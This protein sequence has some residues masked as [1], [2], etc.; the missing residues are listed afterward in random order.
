MRVGVIVAME[1]ELDSLKTQV[2]N[3]K[4]I[5]TDAYEFY[6]ASINHTSIIVVRSGIGKVNAA[7]CAT[8]LIHNFN[9]DMVISTGVAGGLSLKIKPNDVVIAKE[10]TYHDVYCGG[11][12]E[13]GS[14]QGLPKMY[15]SSDYLV[16]A[17]KKVFEESHAGLIVSG[18]KFVHGKVEKEYILK[19]FPNAL[20]VDME[21]CAIA[22]TCYLCNV[23]FM[24]LRVI[25]D[26]CDE[27]E[28][29]RF[30]DEIANVLS[31][32]VLSIIKRIDF[33]YAE[34]DTEYKI[35]SFEIDHLDLKR[36]VYVCRKDR[37]GDEVLTT[38]DVR[39]KE[40]YKDNPLEQDAVHTIEHIGATYLRNMAAIKNDIVYWGPMGC[41]TGFYLIVHGDV[42]VEEIMPY[43]RELFI[44]VIESDSIPGNSRKEC[45]NCELHNLQK[46]KDVALE[47]LRVLLNISKKNKHYPL[48]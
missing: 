16:S 42:G 13:K 20:A 48:R 12:V 22:Q 23:P 30:W 11:D 32:S 27:T 35:K 41:L 7:L 21:S 8:S 29:R 45:G 46:A 9:P 39:I 18:D 24:A 44:K 5:K 36:G 10:L 1:K 17:A 19:D 28:Y 14:I 2:P 15:K 25:S 38:F 34:C 47:Y 3:L 43:I 33:D 40:P 31:F 6:S 4:S 37:Y 26:G